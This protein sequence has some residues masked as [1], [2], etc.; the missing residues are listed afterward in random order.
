M[1][2]S[3]EAL[4]ARMACMGASAWRSSPRWKLNISDDG[5]LSLQELEAMNSQHEPAH[6]FRGSMRNGP[7]RG[8]GAQSRRAGTD[9]GSAERER[10]TNSH[11]RKA[12]KAFNAEAGRGPRRATGVRS[13]PA[14]SYGKCHRTC[15]ALQLPRP[16]P[17]S[18]LNH[19]RCRQTPPAPPGIPPPAAAMYATV[20]YAGGAASQEDAVTM[21][22]S[23][24]PP[25]Q[26]FPR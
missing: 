16:R 14:V 11:R 10:P 15:W 26:A 12:R 23:P 17:A 5:T 7:L 6:H 20:C 4:P 24:A 22:A 13:G 18:V 9:L 1:A 8:P 25:I 19:L 3:G 2:I 21:L